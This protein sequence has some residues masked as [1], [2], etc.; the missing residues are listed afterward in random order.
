M[1]VPKGGGGY[2][3]AERMRPRNEADAQREVMRRPK[4]NARRP[5][6][7]VPSVKPAGSEGD[8]DK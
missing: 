3:A 1:S 4:G 5:L 7:G 2:P 8:K 6:A